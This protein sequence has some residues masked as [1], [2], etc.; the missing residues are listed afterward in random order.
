M[1]KGLALLFAAVVA[2]VVASCSS[3]DSKLHENRGV[4]EPS[5]RLRACVRDNDCAVVDVECDGCCPGGGAV[6]SKFLDV[7]NTQRKKLCSRR[8]SKPRVDCTCAF[9]RARCLN[10]LCVW[11]YQ[12]PDPNAL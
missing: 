6:N 2:G 9:A 10:K 5:T 1:A 12:G 3:V 11:D 4:V 7:F 8:H